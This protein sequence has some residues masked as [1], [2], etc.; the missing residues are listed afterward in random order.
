MSERTEKEEKLMS[1]VQKK[2][3]EFTDMVDTEGSQDILEQ[4]LLTYAKHREDTL[5][6]QTNN[7]ELNSAKAQ[8]SELNSLYK[9]TLDAIKVKSAYL[10]ILIKDLKESNGSEE[11]TG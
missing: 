2:F 4:K 10:H 8:V 1:K 9:P 3:P 6:H 7:A 5:H 11:E